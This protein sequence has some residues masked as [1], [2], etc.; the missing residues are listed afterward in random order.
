[1]FNAFERLIA[2][3]YLRA[4][5]QEGFISVVAWFSLLGIMLGVATLIIVMSVMNGFREQLLSRIV[6]VNGHVEVLSPGRPLGKFRKLAQI[7]RSLDGVVTVTPVV[8]GQVL[9]STKFHAAGALVR[10]LT[11]EDFQERPI[12]KNSLFVGSLNE[13]KSGRGVLVGTRF[14]RRF[15]L[16]LGSMVKLISPQGTNT[17]MGPVPR[18]KTF[19]VSGI[20]RVGMSEYDSNFIYMPL[21]IAQIFFRHKNTVSKLEVIT[22]NPDK[23]DVFQKVIDKEI[24]PLA[25]AM[26]WQQ[27]NS[28]FFEALRVERNVMF[29]ILSLIIIVAAFNI[30]SS[31]VMLVHDKGKGIAILRTMGA[32]R[33]MVLRIFF[34]TGASVGILG[35]MMGS[36]L[37]LLFT[38]NIEAIRQFL[39][40]LLSTELFPA[41]IYFLSRMPS[42]V[43]NFEVTLVIIMA[44]VLSLLASIYPAWKAARMEPVEALRYE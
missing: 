19:R 38:F 20:F 39:Q 17:A 42:K 41:E 29:L 36:T 8:Q 13:F 31:Q 14:A 34:M 18:V 4:R 6:G 22:N 2:F 10:G 23:A 7:V 21:K 28:S 16:E 3:R 35:T 24:R 33:L 37:G 40:T 27:V 25:R 15:G 11:Y 1:M 12:L 9:A 5:R 43:D 44:L 30:I 32:T 26:S